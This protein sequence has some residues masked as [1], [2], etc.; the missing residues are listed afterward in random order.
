M[1]FSTYENDSCIP[2]FSAHT[3][4]KR[5]FTFKFLRFLQLQ[6]YARTAFGNTPSCLENAL[7]IIAKVIF[8]S[9]AGL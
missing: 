7:R 2:T 6:A 5:P 8:L 3:S 9:L 4:P 1:G